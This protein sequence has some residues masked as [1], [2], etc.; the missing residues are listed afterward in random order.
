MGRGEFLFR[1]VLATSFTDP[2]IR[3][4]AE[5]FSAL[6]QL[7]E[8][9]VE[10]VTNEDRDTL[11]KLLEE[12]RFK[13]DWVRLTLLLIFDVDVNLTQRVDQQEILERG[14]TFCETLWKDKPTD[15]KFKILENLACLDPSDSELIGSLLTT[16][17]DLLPEFTDWL[18]S[19]WYNTGECEVV[20]LGR[21]CI[22]KMEQLVL[23]EKQFTLSEKMELIR[24]T[25]NVIISQDEDD[26]LVVHHDDVIVRED[27]FS[28]FGDIDLDV[29]QKLYPFQ[30][31]SAGAG[32][33]QEEE[34]GESEKGDVQ[35]EEED[36]K[37]EFKDENEESEKDQREERR[38]R[39][40][41]EFWLKFDEEYLDDESEIPDEDDLEDPVRIQNEEKDL[42][43]ESLE[44]IPLEV[45]AKIL[46]ERYRIGRREQQLQDCHL[47]PGWKK[48]AWKYYS[49]LRRL[50]RWYPDGNKLYRMK[51]TIRHII[52]TPRK[53]GSAEMKVGGNKDFIHALATMVEKMNKEEIDRYIGGEDEYA[54]VRHIIT[55]GQVV[56][57]EYEDDAILSQ[58]L[59]KEEK[60]IL[61]EITWTQVYQAAKKFVRVNRVPNKCVDEMQVKLAKQ[62]AI[63][64]LY[65]VEEHP[66]RRLELL[67]LR[68]TIPD[69]P[70]ECNWNYYEKDEITLNHYK[71]SDIYHQYR[72]GI[73]DELKRILDSLPEYE[74]QRYIFGRASQIEENNGRRSS[75]IKE[76]FKLICGRPLTSS[77]LRKLYISHQ[78]S[79]GKLRWARDRV[80]LARK[81]GHSVELQQSVY[82]VR[83]H[84][85]EDKPRICTVGQDVLDVSDSPDVPDS[86]LLKRK[87]ED[88]LDLIVAIS[89]EQV[90]GNNENNESGSEDS[91]R[92]AKKVCIDNEEIVEHNLEENVK[93]RSRVPPTESQV[94][95]LEKLI[96]EF[97]ESELYMEQIGDNRSPIY[98]WT[99]LKVK[100]D[101]LKD[102]PDARIK[103]WG[104]TI[105]RKMREREQVLQK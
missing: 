60:E 29:M 21:D 81:M 77:L 84:G 53:K 75:M 93:K 17:E 46:K 1:E 13:W 66:P 7:C 90:E 80:D 9:Q 96:R 100:S 5:Y 11:W 31:P 78:S 30:V 54:K 62:I 47:N 104:R 85:D 98:P 32:E 76:A 16:E 99:T 103:A 3:T 35:G 51:D 64:Y 34:K 19:V 25:R 59:T 61:N 70:I 33:L 48:N 37:I 73:S 14:V 86:P 6:V 91:G 50:F 18:Y 15:E 2:S 42:N 39:Q 105:I 57:K 79:L 40:E 69:D 24:R 43:P 95:T 4:N 89:N 71:T 74:E 28:E 44:P 36:E 22:R 63:A 58:D 55:E 94:A 88:D 10:D 56:M 87:V 26:D 45:V 97:E 101:L 12:K 82:S 92:A 65:V 67:T 72:F 68:R 20:Y 41:K 52:I 83:M 49:E 38:K 23:K 102:V 8:K 27:D